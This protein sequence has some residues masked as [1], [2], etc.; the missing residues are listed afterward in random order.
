MKSQLFGSF[1]MAI[2]CAAF[3]SG[4]AFAADDAAVKGLFG[5]TLIQSGPTW[6]QHTWYN[7]NGGFVTSG[8]WTREGVTGM[9]GADG[10]Y[11][12]ENGKLCQK[13][14]R[15]ETPAACG[16]PGLN[17]KAGDKWDGVNAAGQAEH[18]EVVA[19]HS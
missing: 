7:P 12:I 15:V 8:W 19:G 16:L 10:T 11:S 2:A 5:N 6:E 17:H 3:T 4:A 14:K 1:V 18:Y 13:P 9:G